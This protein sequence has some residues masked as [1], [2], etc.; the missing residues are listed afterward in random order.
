MTIAFPQNL[1]AVS[2]DTPAPECAAGI[3]RQAQAGTEDASPKA[4]S[5][6]DGPSFREALRQAKRIRRM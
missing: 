6:E 5:D 3:R 1:D 2:G 4:S